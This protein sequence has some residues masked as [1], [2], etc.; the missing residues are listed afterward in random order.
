MKMKVKDLRRLIRENYAREIPQFAIDDACA[1]AIKLKPFAAG[2]HCREK[3]EHYFKL[4]INCTSASPAD[5]RRKIIKMHS[6]LSNMEEEIRD[7]KNLKDEL[8]EIVDQHIRRFLF[9]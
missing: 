6:V 5:M 9:I 4:H 2:K 8:K 3:L 1:V 7:L